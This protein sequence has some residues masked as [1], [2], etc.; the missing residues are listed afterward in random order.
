MLSLGHRQFETLVGAVLK[1]L[2][3]AD[4]EVTG[5]T[6]DNGIDAVCAIPF[7]NT[8][9]A[10]QAKRYSLQNTVGIEP[11][12]RL[13]GSVL[14]EGYDRGLFITTSTFTAGAKEAADRAGSRIILVD[15]QRLVEI[16][17]QN[18]VGVRRVPVIKSEIDESFFGM[19]G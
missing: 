8:R 19:M 4:I 18:G 13:I 17:L 15:G 6:A 3:L 2:G 9:V 12:Q 5:R 1:S 7:I 14:T 10:V 16:M 11:V